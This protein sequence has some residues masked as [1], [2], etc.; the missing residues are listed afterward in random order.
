[1]G[2]EDHWTPIAI[3][4]AEYLRRG[5]IRVPLPSTDDILNSFAIWEDRKR[6]GIDWGSGIKFIIDFSYLNHGREYPVTVDGFKW[7]DAL[8][9][10]Q[11]VS[12]HFYS[13]NWLVPEVHRGAIVESLEDK[14]RFQLSE[15]AQVQNL[16]PPDPSTPLVA[17]TLHEA[18]I[19]YEAERK[20]DF[21]RPDGSF[22]NSGHHMLGLIQG[23]RERSSDMPLAGFDFVRCQAL[24]NFWRKRPK[25][26]KTGEPLSKKTCQNHLGEIKR[27][28]T[29][30]HLTDQFGWRRSAD[31][32]DLDLRVDSLPSDRPSLDQISIPTFSIDELVRLYKFA[33]PAERLLL[34]W[35]LNCAHGAAEFGRVE[36]GDLFL[37]QEH[38][39]RKHGL[40]IETTEE[41]GW[42]G[43]IRPK[44]GVLGW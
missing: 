17:G 30:L 7:E 26:D 1:L 10:H 36:W 43:F 14:A 5:D 3:H 44:S 42:C 25:N 18:L 32:D 12:G 16:S 35:S 27:F 2:L 39:W 33:I 31:H 9:I 28:F 15:L 4:A 34:V 21:T 24:V 20:K 6:K 29:W 40:S 19:A 23:V 41:D 37:R 22:S 38:P 13:I 11:L 8:T